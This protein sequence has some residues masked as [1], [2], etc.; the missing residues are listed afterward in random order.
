MSF[1]GSFKGPS[2]LDR[3]GFEAWFSPTPEQAPMWMR[4]PPLASWIRRLDQKARILGAVREAARKAKFVIVYQHNHFCG[5]A[6][7]VKAPP[8]PNTRVNRSDTAPGLV[9]WTHELIDAGASVYVAH[10]NPVSQG[11][12]IYKGRPILYGLG[13]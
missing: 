11:V 3:R 5:E 9:A 13:N 6:T 8:S 4:R 2:G 1:K 7:G 12:E 10:G